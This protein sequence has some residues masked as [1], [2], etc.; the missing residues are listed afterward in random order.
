MMMM[1]GG[2]YKYDQRRP[3]F[4]CFAG[5]SFLIWSARASQYSVF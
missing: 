2:Y 5:V 1:M 4:F 3:L